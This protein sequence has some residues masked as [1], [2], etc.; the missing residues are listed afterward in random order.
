MATQR[1]DGRWPSTQCPAAAALCVR[2]AAA[3]VIRSIAFARS[4]CYKWIY[5]NAVIP[6]NHK[7]YQVLFN[8]LPQGDLQAC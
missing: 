5:S 3:R 6:T 7:R 1:A 4:T 2:V 8:L